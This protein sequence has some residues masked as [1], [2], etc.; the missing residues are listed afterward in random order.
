MARKE[1]ERRYITE[2]MKDTWPKGEWQLNVELGPIPQEY[3]DRYGLGRATA[4]FRPTR[5]RVDAVKWTPQAYYL[6]EAKIRNIKSGIGDLSYYRGMAEKSLD[7]P[8]YEGQP[9]VCRLVVPWMIEWIRVAADAAQVEVVVFSADWID[10]Y[11]EEQKHYY[12]AEYRDARAE[13]LRLR[14]I[15]GVD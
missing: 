13:K 11:I 14:E 8:F 9:L 12:T 7:L 2:Y 6:I 5:P 15:L 4:L 1:R 3:V 10:E